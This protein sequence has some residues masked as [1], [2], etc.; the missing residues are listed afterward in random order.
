MSIGTYFLIAIIV[1]LLA[2]LVFHVVKTYREKGKEA[3]IA[4]MR[5]VA[6]QLFLKAEK[7]YGRDAGKSKM[8]WVIGQFYRL[9][10]PGWLSKF[11]PE[12]TVTDYLQS[13]Y[14][15]YYVKFKDYLD[16]GQING[17]VRAE[18]ACVLGSSGMTNSTMPG[19][20]N[21]N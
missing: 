4:E 18:G 11:L 1:L 15:E 19:M 17:S 10:A 12:T 9:I 21:P 8:E 14:D 2:V 5:E 3:A 13:M 16:D 6:Y 20:P 7:L